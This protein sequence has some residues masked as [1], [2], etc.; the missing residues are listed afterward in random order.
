MNLVKD[1]AVTTYKIEY[2]NI[3]TFIII[4]CVQGFQYDPRARVILFLTHNRNTDTVI[5][6]VPSNP[7]GSFCVYPLTHV[8]H[9][10]CTLQPTWVI[11]YVPSN[12]RGSFYVYYQKQLGLNRIV[13]RLKMLEN[14]PDDDLIH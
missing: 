8:G 11:F 4:S 14:Q 2:S 9:F 6:C 1:I 13:I 7:R 10:V 12:T 3:N 5:L